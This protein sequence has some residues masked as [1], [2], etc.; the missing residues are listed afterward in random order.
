[1]DEVAIPQKN[2]VSAAPSAIVITADIAHL[3]NEKL[4]DRVVKQVASGDASKINIKGRF[5]GTES[6]S[7]ANQITANQLQRKMAQD[8]VLNDPGTPARVERAISAV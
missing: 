6:T 1:M 5:F 2:L 7:V 3:G 8:E 4:S